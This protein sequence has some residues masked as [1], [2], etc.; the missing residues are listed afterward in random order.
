M[1]I[2]YAAMAWTGLYVASKVSFAL[3]GRLGFTGGPRVSP[4]SYQAYGPGEVALAQWANAGSGL[5]IIAVLLLGRLDLSG[6]W[7]RRI[8]L[9]LHWLF[10]AMAAVGGVGM[11]GTGLFTDRGG[12]LFGGYCAVWAV[13]L[14]LT[15]RDLHRRP[16]RQRA[17]RAVRG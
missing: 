10:T 4:D 11:L 9:T 12:A 14:F 2:A 1:K 13:L 17:L 3:D 16:A 8:L 5:L 6:R 7:P 15:T